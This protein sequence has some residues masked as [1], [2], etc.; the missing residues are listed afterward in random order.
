MFLLASACAPADLP[1]GPDV[2]VVGT[3]VGTV[4]R[5]SWSTDDGAPTWVEYGEDG[6]FDHRIDVSDAEGEHEVLLAGLAAGTTWSARAVYEGE[7]GRV[8]GEPESFTTAPPPADLFEPVLSVEPDEA[9]G[10]FYVG[11]TIDGDGSSAFVLDRLGRFTWWA[12]TDPGGLTTQARLSADGEWI[13]WLSDEP[14]AG[15]GRMRLDGSE[16]EL[17]SVAGAHHDFFDLGDRW[18]V[19]VGDD[20][21]VNGRMVRG[22]ALVEVDRDGKLLRTLWSAWDELEPDLDRD[23]NVVPGTETLDWTH[24]NSFFWDEAQGEVLLSLYGLWAVAAVDIETGE[25][26]WMVSG[27]DGGDLALAEGSS[28]GPAHSPIPTPRGFAIFENGPEERLASRVVEYEVDRAAGTVT[29]VESYSPSPSLFAAV[30]GNI[31]DE[32]D[33]GRFLGWGTAGRL[34]VL[35]AEGAERT[36]IDVALGAGFGFVHHVPVLAGATR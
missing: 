14:E 5:A 15:I 8:R 35:D 17:V 30:L 28:L 19:V 18:V 31:A 12:E 1:P 33:G 20:R 11:T 6:A 9:L 24:L 23:M 16:T 13:E 34:Q 36:R 2:A 21:R 26:S 22:D 27:L 3:D 32:P 25:G 4:F 29:E 7:E 10:G